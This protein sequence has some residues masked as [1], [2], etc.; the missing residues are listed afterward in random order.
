[1]FVSCFCYKQG[2]QL[3]S[4]SL[5]AGHLLAVKLRRFYATSEK[6]QFNNKFL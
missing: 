5:V 1:M 3:R 6:K 4:G 2:W